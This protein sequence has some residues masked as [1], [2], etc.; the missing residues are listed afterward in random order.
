VI[1]KILIAMEKQNE[2]RARGGAKIEVRTVPILKW[3]T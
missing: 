1:T 2:R 3:K